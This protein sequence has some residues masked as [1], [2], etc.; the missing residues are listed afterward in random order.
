M[1]IVDGPLFK[2]YVL[3]REANGD[4]ARP[5]K[6]QGLMATLT[7]PLENLSAKVRPRLAGMYRSVVFA[8][9]TIRMEHG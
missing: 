8:D 2:I 7:G 5:F 4:L 3:G 6:K 1:T 9:R